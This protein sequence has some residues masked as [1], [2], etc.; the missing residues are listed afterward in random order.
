MI[1]FYFVNVYGLYDFDYYIM[2][3][4]MVMFFWVLIVEML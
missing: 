4:D 1:V 2:L 3:R